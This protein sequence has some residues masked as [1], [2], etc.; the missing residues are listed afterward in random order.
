MIAHFYTT[1]SINI[2]YERAHLLLLK[3]TLAI[4]GA[5]DIKLPLKI[6]VFAAASLY[7]PT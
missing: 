4:V 7:Y 2:I 6:E 1:K 5:I 3:N